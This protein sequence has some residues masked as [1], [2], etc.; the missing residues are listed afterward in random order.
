MLA[1][2]ARPARR[3]RGTTGNIMVAVC[4]TGMI[5]DVNVPMGPQGR[6]GGKYFAFFANTQKEDERGRREACAVAGL[7]IY[8][9]W[10]P[11]EVATYAQVGLGT[12]YIRVHA[13]QHGRMRN[14]ESNK[15]GR[16]AGNT[17][18]RSWMNML[19]PTFAWIGCYKLRTTERRAWWHKSRWGPEQRA[20]YV[21]GLPGQPR[22]SC[23]PAFVPENSSGE[24]TGKGGIVSRRVF[25][26]VRATS[27]GRRLAKAPSTRCRDAVTGP[28]RICVRPFVFRFWRT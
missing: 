12:P 7:H 9:G 13:R 5:L 26:L 16:G 28:I 15:R 6:F 8:G 14:S 20:S 23:L 27:D 18:F 2:A 3:A 1:A 17:G 4:W 22:Y 25:R 11:C 19:A 21:E 24:R 10:R